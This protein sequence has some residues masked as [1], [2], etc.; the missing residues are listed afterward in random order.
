[1]FKV[2]DT[3]I[4]GSVGLCTISEIKKILFSGVEK[5]Y[6]LLLPEANKSTIYVPVD[7]KD[8]KLRDLLSKEEAEGLMNSVAE[9]ESLWQENS[10]SRK[11]IF[12]DYMKTGDAF[13]VARILK[14]MYLNSQEREKAGKKV[15]VADS[16]ITAEAERNLFGE[17][18]VVLKKDRE[19]IRK[20]FYD[21]IVL[22]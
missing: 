22:S 5:E 7:Q 14:D 11:M 3:V 17:L 21:A 6:Y 8:G 4:Y 18:S 20:E 2:N 12:Q 10:L 15:H 13:L 1:M 19:E 9:M 16:K